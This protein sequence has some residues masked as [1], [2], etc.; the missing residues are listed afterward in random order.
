QADILPRAKYIEAEPPVAVDDGKGLPRIGRLIERRHLHRPRGEISE[1]GMERH[2]DDDHD[3]SKIAERDA[4]F[5]HVVSNSCLP[6]GY[7]R[8]GTSPRKFPKGFVKR[9]YLQVI[10]AQTPTP[11]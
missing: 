1:R 11:A 10:E 9:P 3:A 8:N 2:D 6:H 4:R 5:S 7:C